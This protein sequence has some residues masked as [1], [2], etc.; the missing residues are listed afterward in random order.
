[1]LGSEIE[2]PKVMMMTWKIL[3]NLCSFLREIVVNLVEK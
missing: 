2:I 1:M 3:E